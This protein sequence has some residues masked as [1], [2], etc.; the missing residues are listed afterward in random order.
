MLSLVFSDRRF[1]I[2]LITVLA[3]LIFSHP[4]SAQ[5]DS[6][7]EN[8]IAEDD[9]QGNIIDW[10][11]MLSAN[12][13]DINTISETYLSE[14]PFLSQRQVLLILENRPFANKTD[15]SRLLGKSTYAKIRPFI[16]IS[17]FHR[18]PRLI[19]THRQGHQLEKNRA[20]TTHIFTGSPYES[21][22]RLRIKATAEISAG[23]LI[24]KDAGERRLD[25]HAC[26]YLAWDPEK[27]P[28]KIIAGNFYCHS[29][30]GLLLSGSYL[31]SAKTLTGAAPVNSV[32]VL[33]PFLS[34][35]ESDGFFGG[36]IAI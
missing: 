22:T 7:V 3:M 9:E 35:N 23:F 27:L 14:L 2:N 28:L 17:R 31:P 33:K 4:L 5:I 18:Y 26:G 13:V 20:I 24:Q 32:C 8:L 25:D 36:A 34:G 30:E 12:P 19:L 11:E 29:A 6:L 16:V 21:L 1:F 10:I 15:L